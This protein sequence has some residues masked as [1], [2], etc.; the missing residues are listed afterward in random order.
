MYEISD[1]FLF[2]FPLSNHNCSSMNLIFYILFF[3]TKPEVSVY[4]TSDS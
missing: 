1:S 4:E 2:C 3:I